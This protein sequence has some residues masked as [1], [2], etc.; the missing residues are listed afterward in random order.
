MKVFAGD[1]VILEQTS[2]LLPG[3]C[4]YVLLSLGLFFAMPV[5]WV[6]GNSLVPL[7]SYCLVS[8]A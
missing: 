6:C 7:Q 3:P 2:S 5:F 8:K 1:L 4:V